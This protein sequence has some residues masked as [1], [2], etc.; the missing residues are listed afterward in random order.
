M[1][2]ATW[3]CGLAFSACAGVALADYPQRQVTFLVP[4]PP[5]DTGDQVARLIAEDMTR[6]T[7]IP[8]RVV[9][10]AG[11]GGVEGAASVARSPADGYMIGVFVIDIP[12]M[13]VIRGNAP[14]GADAFEPVGILTTIP[15]GLVALRDAPYDNMA[16]LA[17]YA[18]ENPVRLA[19]FGY[20][21]IPTAATFAAAEAL[22]FEYANDT[23][24]EMVNCTTLTNGDADVMNTTMQ[25]VL[26]CLDDIKVIAA[27]TSE[28]L[29]LAPEAQLLS[30][31]VPGLDITLWGGLFVPRGTPREVIDVI[32]EHAER[33][34]LGERAQGLAEASGSHVY[35]MGPDEAAELVARDFET[36]R[37][38]AEGR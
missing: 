15:F 37:R 23:A 18:R 38:L 17:E 14:Y 27:Y 20:D 32:A 33:T 35:W 9:N 11:G 36:A 26:A 25:L 30:E 29:I 21:L 28:P 3:L 1:K 2:A 8:A 31:A 6:E 16:E 12:T 4:W 13:H 34:V 10:R 22:D 7:G 5:G 19:H 24:Y